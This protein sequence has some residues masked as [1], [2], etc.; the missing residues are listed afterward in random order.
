VAAPYA[1]FARL[2]VVRDI[3]SPLARTLG[4]DLSH[5]TIANITDAVLEE[6]KAWQNR[7]LDPVW[8]VVFLDA[9]V[10]KVRDGAHVV[11]RAAHLA[12]GVDTDGIKHVLGIWVQSAEGAKSWA[13][14]CSQ[15]ANRGVCDI[16]IACCDGLPGLRVVLELTPFRDS[17]RPHADHAAGRVPKPA[18]LDDAEVRTPAK[19]TWWCSL[20]ARPRR[21]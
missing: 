16:L 7:P 6:V 3:Q 1:V 20:R 19:A 9:L 5:E 8:P 2:N 15:V 12:I 11:N 18:G 10:V 14:V 4:M 21:Q 17:R 13:G